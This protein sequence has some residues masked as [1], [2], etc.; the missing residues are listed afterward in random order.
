[1]TMDCVSEGRLVFRINNVDL[2][3]HVTGYG[4]V[5]MVSSLHHQP[6]PYSQVIRFSLYPV[7]VRSDRLTF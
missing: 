5:T 2:V 7:S 6:V 3:R 4:D 1:M